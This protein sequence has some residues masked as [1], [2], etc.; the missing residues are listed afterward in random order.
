MPAEGLDPD[1]L[2]AE[3]REPRW[4][5]DILARFAQL[6]DDIGYAGAPG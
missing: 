4:G 3:V 1:R 2:L 6:A 5:D